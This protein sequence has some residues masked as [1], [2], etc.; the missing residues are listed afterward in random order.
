MLNILKDRL[1]SILN[2]ENINSITLTDGRI[3]DDFNTLKED[4]SIDLVGDTRFDDFILSYANKKNLYLLANDYAYD[5]GF[6][7]LNDMAIREYNVCPQTYIMPI[8][9][10]L[11]SLIGNFLDEYTT[12]EDSDA[13]GFIKRSYE[14]YKIICDELKDRFIVTFNMNE[15]NIF[16]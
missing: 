7:S 13:K 14:A 10:A 4:D 3:V 11:L 12:L 6:K 9:D 5:F 15:T 8:S 2:E 16:E 1:I